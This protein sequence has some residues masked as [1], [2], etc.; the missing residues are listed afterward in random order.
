MLS[1]RVLLILLPVASALSSFALPIGEGTFSL[2]LT[3][4]GAHH[5]TLKSR[6]PVKLNYQQ[7]GYVATITVGKRE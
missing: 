5:G 4:V 1:L 6:G 3:P 2:P 7:G